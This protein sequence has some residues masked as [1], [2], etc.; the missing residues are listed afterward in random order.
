MLGTF[1]QQAIRKQTIT[2]YGKGTGV[3]EMIYVKDAASAVEAAIMHPERRGVFNI[4]SGVAT[5]HNELA[6][7]VN[8]IFAY[9]A[10]E[11]VHDPTK[12]EA[13]TRYPMDHSKAGKILGWNPKYTVKQALS[14]LKPE[15]LDALGSERISF[16]EKPAGFIQTPSE[17]DSS[18]KA[19]A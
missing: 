19:T 8:E 13:S 1:I 10:A 18:G 3:R 4:G 6:A 12:E 14:E 11:I 17:K 2:V 9:G 7:L 16:E 5:S 15:I